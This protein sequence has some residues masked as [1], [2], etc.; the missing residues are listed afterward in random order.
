MTAVDVKPVGTLL[1]EW[2]QRRR[3]SQL[4]LANAADISTRHLSFLETGRAAPSREMVLRL[5][6][7]LDLPLRERNTLL[8]AAGFA[9]MYGQRRLDHPTLAGAR[10]AI[11]RVLAAH[12]PYPALVI[13]RYW[14][15]VGANRAV[16]RLLDGVDPV[17]L[18]P[19]V[20]VLRLSLHPA[21]LAP[22][23]V[24]LGEWRA[25]L[26]SRLRQQ[27]DASADARLDD[28]LRELR[29]YPARGGASAGGPVDAAVVVPL[30]LATAFGTL[31]LLSTTTVFGTPVEVTLAE[32]AIESFFPA[33]A[34]TA[35]R[36][37]RLAEAG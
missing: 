27:I 23:I 22:R 7:R 6:E 28:L 9:P 37:R 4:E 1:R 3:L 12:D 11:E 2:R 17:L 10:E 36:L 18:A 25:H 24:N 15:L 20:N 31:R 33:D 8:L 32:L 34:A 19:P 29:G 21:G 16:H 13:D 26:L 14:V 35:Q 5:A 30:V